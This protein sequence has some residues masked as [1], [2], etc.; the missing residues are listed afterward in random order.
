MVCACKPVSPAETIAQADQRFGA[1][2]PREPH[3]YKEGCRSIC[4]HQV[5]NRQSLRLG[6]FANMYAP[7]FS[8]ATSRPRVR[9]NGA[10]FVFDRWGHGNGQKKLMAVEST[11]ERSFSVLLRSS[12]LQRR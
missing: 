4:I 6:T 12:V 7:N 3:Q 8:R 11:S 9:H 10:D 1:A 2:Y 5:G